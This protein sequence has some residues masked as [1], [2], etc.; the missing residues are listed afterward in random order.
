[1]LLEWGADLTAQDK[2]CKTPLHVYFQGRIVEAIRLLLEKGADPTVQDKN[3][4]TPSQCASATAHP[5][6]VQFWSR[7][8]G[9]R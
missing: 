7:Y 3:G 6:V 9:R 2:D 8:E 5:H 1:M 4:R